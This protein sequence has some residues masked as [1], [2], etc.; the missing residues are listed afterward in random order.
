M[1]SPDKQ[2]PPDEPP[3][4]PPRPSLRSPRPPARSPRPSSKVL[5]PS[6][7]ALT[8]PPGTPIS[9]SNQPLHTPSSRSRSKRRR[10]PTQPVRLSSALARAVAASPDCQAPNV[11]A[12]VLWHAETQ[13]GIR[14]VG[15][16]PSIEAVLFEEQPP[17][18]G[19]H[20]RPDP[21]AAEEV[22]FRASS[23]SPSPAMPPLRNPPRPLFCADLVW[24]FPESTS[25]MQPSA[26]SDPLRAFRKTITGD[27]CL[28][29]VQGMMMPIGCDWDDRY[30]AVVHLFQPPAFQAGSA[31]DDQGTMSRHVRFRVDDGTASIICVASVPVLTLD[32]DRVKAM[33]VF[34]DLL[35]QAL[36]RPWRS[37]SVIGLA[38][39]SIA[40]RQCVIYVMG[41]GT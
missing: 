35:A 28:V 7:K 11:L 40:L 14:G 20:P 10:V 19:P 26:G 29:H 5:R 39:W 27:S 24:L 3:P 1:V 12:E 13:V 30:P 41:F 4:G 32:S 15:P 2:G 22:S 31:K 16:G 37:V 9:S 36:V 17:P 33:S 21:K 34:D 38:R 6:S 25:N 8:D 18:G 23:R